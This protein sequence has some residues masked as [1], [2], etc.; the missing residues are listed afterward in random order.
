M[1][2]MSLFNKAMEMLGYA[3]AEGISGREDMLKKALTLI[4]LVYSELYYAFCFVPG[5]KDNFTPLK[6]MSEKL[7]LPNV[8]LN[9]IAP[10]GVAMYLAQSESDADN[11]NLYAA[12]YNQKKIRGKSISK[13]KDCA[14]HVWG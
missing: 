11:Q 3:S 10:Y 13:V 6:T 8:V 1:T 2:A 4:N 12:I 5:E 14:P 9:D 7:A